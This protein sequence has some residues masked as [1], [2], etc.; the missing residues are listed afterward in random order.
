MATQKLGFKIAVKNAYKLCDF[1][2]AYGIIFSEYIKFYD[3]WGI[4]D[5]DIVFGRMSEF[6]TEEL[7]GK[8]DVISVRN[9]YPT[10]S[11]M[12]FKNNILINN[13]FKKSK[14]Y[15]KVFQSDTHYCFDECNFKHNFLQGGVDIFDIDCD[16]ESM[17]HV[18]KKEEAMNGLKAHFDLLIIEGLPGQLKFEKG[19]LTFKNEFEVLLHHLILYKANRYARKKEWKHVPN[20][21]YI[22]KYLIRKSKSNSIKGFLVYGIYNK[23]I[24]YLNKLIFKWEYT[25]SNILFIK[26]KEFRN[27]SYKLNGLDIKIANNEAKE[28]LIYFNGV[29]ANNQLIKSILNKN[30]FFVQS[31][32]SVK[33]H[34]NEDKGELIELRINGLTQT[35]KEENFNQFS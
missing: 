17:H 10:G 13:L 12:L 20:I 33:Y 4:T 29:K 19:L 30:S 26:R 27:N 31:F 25:I 7:L 1:K 15:K 8:Y 34:L 18:I 16:I 2:P 11:F 5:I 35:F 23:I 21:F 14:D 24:P 22:D 3:F 32:P 9:D 28:N 6:M